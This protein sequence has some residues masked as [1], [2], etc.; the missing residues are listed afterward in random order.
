MRISNG[1]WIESYC[2][3]FD[4]AKAGVDTW[5][6]GELQCLKLRQASKMVFE[7]DPSP[8]QIHQILAAFIKKVYQA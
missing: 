6:K 4:K 1:N 2:V 3:E 7:R 8:K 5:Y